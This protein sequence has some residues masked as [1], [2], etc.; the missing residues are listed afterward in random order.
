MADPK[1]K[2]DPGDY[3]IAQTI[4]QGNPKS[5]VSPT[6][7]DSPKHTP[8][9]KNAKRRRR[10]NQNARRR[11]EAAAASERLIAEALAQPEVVAI[12]SKEERIKFIQ[13]L[14]DGLKGFLRQFDPRGTFKKNERHWGLLLTLILAFLMSPIT[15]SFMQ[16]RN[17]Q[18][19]GDQNAAQSFLNQMAAWF[20]VV[21]LFNF[22][23]VLP[24]DAAFASLLKD[25]KVN[26]IIIGSM[27]LFWLVYNVKRLI[28]DWR[29]KKKLKTES[30]GYP[31]RRFMEKVL[32]MVVA[33]GCIISSSLCTYYMATLF[34]W[35]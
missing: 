9:S 26:F 28:T 31:K 3:L 32:L 5:S 12:P 20:V 34:G 30:Q 24:F 13:R 25:N 35:R 22:I 23:S 21:M 29:F 7:S 19:R 11:R 1:K 16:W 15:A 10:K 2:R 4:K 27:W 18:S 6:T 33:W 17:A 14:K 8:T